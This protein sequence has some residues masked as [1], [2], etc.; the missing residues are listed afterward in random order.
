M[1]K[2]NIISSRLYSLCP[3]I[4][5]YSGVITTL[6]PLRIRI[7]F[8]RVTYEKLPWIQ[9]IEQLHVPLDFYG[10]SIEPK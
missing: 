2:H 8:W 7:L 9:Q 6:T 4:E 5:N 10:F 1:P 3:R